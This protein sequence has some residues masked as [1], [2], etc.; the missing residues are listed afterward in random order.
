MSALPREGLFGVGDYRAAFLEILYRR[1]SRDRA[2]GP[3]SCDGGTGRSFEA[4]GWRVRKDGSRFWAHV[5]IDPIRDESGTLVG[6]AK[7][8]RD[9]TERKRPRKRS[10]RAR[11]GSACWSRASPT[12]RSTCSTRKGTSRTGTPGAQRIKG[13][14]GAEIVG[15][16]FSRFY[17]DEERAA[18]MPLQALDTAARE[19]RF[20]RKA[21]ASARTAAG[22]WRTSSSMPIRDETGELDRIRQ[23]DPRHHRAEGKPR[24]QLEKAARGA[25]P[26]AEDGGNRPAHR[27]DRPRLQQPS[28]RH[29]GQSR[30]AEACRRRAPAAS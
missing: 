29:H 21:G 10:G 20:E 5:V 11:S 14:S 24:R 17:T 27:R 12:T 15:Q 4:E 23:G 1:G 26:G 30:Y 3:G 19:G 13:Y 6:F 7:I 2:A 9:I 8:T 28:D 22:S 25:L 16:H 18:G